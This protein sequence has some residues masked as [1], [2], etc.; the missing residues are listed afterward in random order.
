MFKKTALSISI[1]VLSLSVAFAA[2]K[3]K[4]H[5]DVFIAGDTAE[6]HMARE[7]RHQLV[8]LPYYGVFDDLAFR[9]D[10]GTV[11]LLGAVTRP[12]L[13]SDAENVTK[14]VEGV[15]NVV[16]NIE[17]LPLSPMDDQIRRAEYRV[18]YGDPTLSTRYGFR[19]LPSI[20]IIVRN[21]HV[22]LEGV[23]ANEGD[24]D[25]INIR[26]NGVPGVFSVTNDLQL[27]G[28]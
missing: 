1:C 14:R 28:K 9:V 8:M 17:V 21:G 7:V 18:I 26:A 11:T 4:N 27:E 5:N 15:T 19:A 13:K 10:Q 24:K 2:K 20:H 25:L 22:T 6:N 3:D 16:N 12:T 23:V